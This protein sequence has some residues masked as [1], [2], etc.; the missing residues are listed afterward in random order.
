MIHQA[1]FS[2][3][4]LNWRIMSYQRRTHREGWMIDLRMTHGGDWT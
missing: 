2:F 3:M 1:D 4:L